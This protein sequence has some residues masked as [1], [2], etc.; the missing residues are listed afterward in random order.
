M[1]NELGQG[2]PL[3][4]RRV[5][6]VA[7]SITITVASILSL[8]I[9]FLRDVFGYIFSNEEEVITYVKKLAPLLSIFLITDGL[10]GVFSG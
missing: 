8:T 4:A 2:N 5:A 1:S 7:L 3:G 9:Y 6:M 10:Q